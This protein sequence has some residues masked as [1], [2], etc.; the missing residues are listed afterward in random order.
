MFPNRRRVGGGAELTRILSLPRRTINGEELIAP[1]TEALKTPRG[2]WKLNAPQAQ[3]LYDIGTFGGGFLPL[4]VGSGKTLITLLA[5]LMVDAKRPVLLLPAALIG[6]TNDEIRE[7]YSPHW[8]VPTSIRMISYEMLGRVQGADY[9]STWK[10]DLIIA[11]E[12]FRLKSKRAGVTKRVARYMR[13]NPE[14]KFVAASGT[15]MKDSLRDF[16]HIMRWCLKDG[17]P[18]PQKEEDLD[19][20]ADALDIKIPVFQRL[21]PGALTA[22]SGGDADLAAVRRGFQKRILET[23]MVVGS[24]GEEV[25]CS[26]YIEGHVLS[27][28]PITEAHFTTLRTKWETPEGWAFSEAVDLWRHARELAL[29]FHYSWEVPGPE[30]WLNARRNWSAKVRLILAH[31]RTLDTE[32]QVALAYPDD[33]ELVAW[34]AIRDTFIPVTRATWHDPSA[35]E[36]CAK[37]MAKGPG[38]VWTSHTLFAEALSKA[39]GRP[40]F[41]AEGTDVEGIPI[42]KAS[43]AV[44]ASIAANGTGRNLQRWNRSLITSMPTTAPITEQLLGRTHRQGQEADAVYVDVLLGCQEHVSAVTKV[45]EAAEAQKDLLGHSQKLLV[46]DLVMP[47]TPMVGARWVAVKGK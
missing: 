11:D 30:G 22:L 40:Y 12:C 39:T 33:P 27:V 37:W 24:S 6:K 45:R 7:T 41:G 4:R 1:L 29:G 14:T 9:L 26:L 17:T 34:S 42:E 20:W 35:L 43:G 16:A 28:Q 31:S 8:R 18:L 44:I 10:P 2:T 46:S 38:I 25:A 5:P 21:D 36:Y 3:A 32:L 13:E 47:V 15:I 19:E 23:P